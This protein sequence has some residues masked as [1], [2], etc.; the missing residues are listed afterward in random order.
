MDNHASSSDED[1]FE[2]YVYDYSDEDEIDDGD[3]QM[4]IEATDPCIYSSDDGN[5]SNNSNTKKKICTPRSAESNPN[6]APMGIDK[7]KN[8]RVIYC[9][10]SNLRKLD[11]N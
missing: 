5:E 2:E 4:S 6:A 11:W 1:D 3:S 10:V 7:G 8:Q 9:H